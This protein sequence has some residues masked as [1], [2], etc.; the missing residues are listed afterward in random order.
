[1]WPWITL[2]ARRLAI[3]LLE[4]SN[5]ESLEFRIEEPERRLRCFAK[6]TPAL[7]GRAG[8][9]SPIC[10]KSFGAG[11]VRAAACFSSL[12]ASAFGRGWIAFSAIALLT[13][14]VG[15]HEPHSGH[16]AW[17]V[18]ICC[19]PFSIAAAMPSL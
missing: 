19:P 5:A 2:K 18:F 7:R 12:K 9:V 13:R 16:L 10:R 1:M 14:L 8:T 15:T 3:P 6:R 11:I 17:V 4:E